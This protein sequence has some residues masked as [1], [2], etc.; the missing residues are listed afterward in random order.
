MCVSVV[1]DNNQHKQYFV[2]FIKVLLCSR[3]NDS[4]HQVT[5]SSLNKSGLYK[6]QAVT[7]CTISR[8]NDA[9]RQRSNW[10]VSSLVFHSYLSG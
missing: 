3:C 8:K 10:S 4:Q 2:E 1:Y 9:E 5:Q 7:F 6:W